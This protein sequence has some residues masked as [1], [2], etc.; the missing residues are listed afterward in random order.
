MRAD[1]KAFPFKKILVGLA[2][3]ETDHE[4]LAYAR[5]LYGLA[6]DVQFQFV[7]VLGVPGEA[8]PA[9]PA[10]AFNILLAAV[11]R[12]FPEAADSAGA[13]C[14]VVEGSR[15]DRL[16]EVALRE[17][18]DLVLIGHRPDRTGRRS[19]A[20]RLAM[21]AP[22]SLWMAPAGSPRSITRVLAA[23]DFSWHSA[24]AL[25]V[26]AAVAG[27]AGL[28]S[29]LALN[30]HFNELTIGWGDRNEEIRRIKRVELQQL[31]EPLDLGGVAVESRFVES[32]R[33]AT[34]IGNTAGQEK[35]DLL[36]MGTRGRSPSAAV[37]LGSETEQV[38]LETRIP[39]LIVK[40]PGERDNL[41]QVLLRGNLRTEPA[42]VG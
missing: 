10:E 21:K 9:S 35:A 31:L 41:L 5:M 15:I 18:N 34:A 42:A 2:G 36:V 14:H 30:V 12:S 19:M 39:V 8:I 32:F 25:S 40:A 37:L 3:S 17:Q 20:R 16:L 22:C 1:R 6:A 13:A 26:G 33:V 23:V 24:L 27:S 11:R 4:L 7:H 29:C 28:E 38:I